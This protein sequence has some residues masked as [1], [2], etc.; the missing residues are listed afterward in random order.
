MTSI[1]AQPVLGRAIAPCT[2][3]RVSLRR[4]PLHITASFVGK[5]EGQEYTATL[6]GISAPFNN[7][8]FDPAGLTSTAKPAEIKRWREAELTHGRVAMLA[9]VGFLVGEQLENFPAFLNVDGFIKGPAITQFQQVESRGAIFWEPLVLVIGICEAY[10]VAVGWSTPVGTGFNTL[11]DDYSPG[12]LGFDPFGLKP[13]NPKE[14]KD[15]QT[16]ELNNGRLAMIA[17]AGF[18]GQELAQPGVEIYEHLFL[19]VGS[20]VIAQKAEI[21]RDTLSGV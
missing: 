3:K 17:I 4:A 21:V 1:I 16:R 5:T 13:T 10:R 15:T 14:L 12:D 19:D 20:S 18:V 7:P 9:A 2:T 6:P 11:K 8:Y